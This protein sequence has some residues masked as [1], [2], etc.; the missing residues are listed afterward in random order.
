MSDKT[1]ATMWIRDGVL[2]E[3][4]H[5]NAVAFAFAVLAFSRRDATEGAPVHSDIASADPSL[6]Q[7]ITFAFAHSGASCAAKLQTL[8]LELEN[9]VED[10]AV[11]ARYY[12]ELATAA[13]QGC[14]PFAHAASLLAT[15]E[16][17]GIPT[18][19]TSAVDQQIMDAWA[20]SSDGQPLCAHVTEVLAQRPGF[21]KG[22]DHFNHVRSRYG[23][24][25]IVLIADAVA[26]IEM[27]RRWGQEYGVV[28]IGFANVIDAAKIN[29]GVRLVSKAQELIGRRAAVAAI[30]PP[31]GVDHEKLVLPDA[32]TLSVLLKN[33][34][35]AYVVSGPAQSLMQTLQ[36]HFVSA[37]ILPS[38]TA[39]PASRE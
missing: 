32:E 15:L 38:P 12:D 7:L 33:A 14:R 23:I 29:E 3:R 11:A 8:N 30:S 13:A 25:R 1:V 21:S 35:A 28:P 27:G 5:V 26:E 34:G 22:G 31:R 4:M 2:V 17:A 20:R 19:I 36:M 9:A 10:V 24:E 16:A 18:F 39:A 37:G 6:E